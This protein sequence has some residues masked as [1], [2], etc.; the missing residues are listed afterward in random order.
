MSDLI[1]V[2]GVV[3][4]SMPVG[5]Y[6]RRV[7]LLTK[8]R[9]KIAAFAKG[10]RRPNSPFMAAANPFVFGTFTLYEGKSSY[11]LNHVEIGYH[12]AELAARQP[13]VYYGYYFLELADYFG[14][15]GIDETE[16]MNLLFMTVKALLNETI[17]NRLVRCIYELRL[18]TIQGL[19]PRLYECTSCGK[20]VPGETGAWFSFAGHGVMDEASSKKT[21]S[22]NWNMLYTTIP[23][24]I[25]I[26]GSKVLRSLI[27]CAAERE[28]I[29]PWNRTGTLQG[30]INFRVENEFR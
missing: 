8:E 30:G 2:Q 21:I 9:G 3:L 25:Q 1:A 12:F 7:V 16:T 10:A 29:Q 11:T 5:E 27:S 6:D 26:N 28:D 15:E 22:R 23:A 4:S 20:E 14:R 24:A 13:A 17:D 19:M 18:L